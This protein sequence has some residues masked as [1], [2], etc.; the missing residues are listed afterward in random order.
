MEFFR[1][2]NQYILIEKIILFNPV[3][4]YADIFFKQMLVFSLESYIICDYKMFK[5]IRK[6]IWMEI[7]ESIT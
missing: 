7:D 6:N 5:A 2:N 1:K 3:F 4:K